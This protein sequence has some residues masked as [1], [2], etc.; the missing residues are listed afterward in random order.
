MN[1]G[2]VR[3]DLPAGEVSYADVATIQPFGNEVS[4]AT[5]SGQAILDTL[6]NQW[7]TEGDRPRLA[8]GVSEGFTYTY[9]PSAPQGERIIDA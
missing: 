2:G 1:A 8:L 7:K 5:M 3:A 4:M 9:D 6:E